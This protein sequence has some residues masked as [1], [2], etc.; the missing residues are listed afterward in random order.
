V[1]LCVF[2]YARVHVSFFRLCVQLYGPIFVHC[3]GWT[4]LFKFYVPTSSWFVL[5]EPFRLMDACSCWD[6]R[7]SCDSAGTWSCSLGSGMAQYNQFYLFYCCA[8]TPVQQAP[9]ATGAGPG[10][11]RMAAVN[12]CIEKIKNMYLSRNTVGR[13]ARLGAL[14][15]V[16]YI[17]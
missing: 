2:A 12:P 11:Q 10:S 17:H 9:Q 16:S 13:M 4:L 15:A 3:R 5:N 8:P 1:C 6:S 14:V 7:R